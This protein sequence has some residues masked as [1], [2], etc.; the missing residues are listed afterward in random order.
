[1]H[2]LK[3][4]VS[5]TLAVFAA[6]A[7][8]QTTNTNK[9][10]FITNPAVGAVINAGDKIDIEWQNLRGDQVTIAIMDGAASDLKQVRTVVTGAPNNGKYTWEVPANIPRS[11]TYSIRISYDNDPDHYN[12]SDRFTVLSN[13]TADP[14]S[15]SATTAAPATTSA[16][17]TGATSSRPSTAS[18]DDS[19][20]STTIRTSTSTRRTST[21]ESTGEPTSLG[22]PPSAGTSTLSSPLAVIMA[23]LA[24]AIFIH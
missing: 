9:P 24:A 17:T 4:A 20:S 15:S 3:T 16:A 7:T 12:Y 8:A 21:S 14:V 1:M 23:V 22:A 10:N 2:F 5:L 19:E 18:E 6:V 11:G 13:V